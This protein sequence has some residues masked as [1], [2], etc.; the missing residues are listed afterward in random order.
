MKEYE[1]KQKENEEQKLKKL[2]SKKEQEYASEFVA[3]ETQEKETLSKSEIK[4]RVNYAYTAST[5]LKS[6]STFDSSVNKQLIYVPFHKLNSSL[7]YATHSWLFNIQY[8][9]TGQR[10]I[11]TDNLW[12]L[13]ANYLIDIGVD[14][15]F[16]L[17]N[18]LNCS[19]GFKVRNVFDQ[20]YQSI[21]WRPM[22]G[23]NYLLSIKMELR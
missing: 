23:R 9:Y 10:Y 15:R 11:S 5:N 1:K 2:E 21:A 16:R 4:A 17:N 19:V 22:P 14:K 18:Q 8:N 3:S 12:Y 6:S 13:P 20:E 7:T